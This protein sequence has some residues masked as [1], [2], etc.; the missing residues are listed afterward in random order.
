MSRVFPLPPSVP[1]SGRMFQSAICFHGLKDGLSVL[2]SVPDTM[3]DNCLAPVG[4]HTPMHRPPHRHTC[5]HVT[6]AN[7]LGDQ[8]CISCAMRGQFHCCV[9]GCLRAWTEERLIS[10]LCIFGLLLKINRQHVL[11]F[12][13]GLTFC[14]PAHVLV[15]IPVSSHSAYYNLVGQFEMG[16]IWLHLSIWLRLHI[17][18]CSFRRHFRLSKV[19]GTI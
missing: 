9:C 16:C 6:K 15:L 19:L 4:P 10:L 3:S 2:S 18:L 8:V 14:S 12:I 11:G 5:I 7:L 1:L 13:S 17:W